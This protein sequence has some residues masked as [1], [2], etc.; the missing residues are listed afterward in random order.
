M[1]AVFNPVTIILNGS[2]RPIEPGL[3]VSQLLRELRLDP[4]FL[5]VEINRCVIPRQEHDRTELRQ[6]DAVEVV[7]LVG[8]G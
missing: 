4:K 2:V 1:V 7:T 6:D 3:T 5:A 8:G